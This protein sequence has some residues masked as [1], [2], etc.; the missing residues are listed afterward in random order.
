MS[1]Q[2]LDEPRARTEGQAWKGL[3]RS[4]TGAALAYPRRVDPANARGVT[5]ERS[6]FD[7]LVLRQ[8]ALLCGQDRFHLVEDAYLATSGSNVFLTGF[9]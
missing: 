8:R 5:A 9:Q 7:P 3:A 2:R 4:V 1:V 6:R